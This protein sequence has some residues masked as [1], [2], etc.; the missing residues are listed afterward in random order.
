MIAS[1]AAKGNNSKEDEA[2]A[3]CS[4]GRGRP[5]PSKKNATPEGKLLNTNHLTT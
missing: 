2:V 4:R 5:P 3:S 1:K